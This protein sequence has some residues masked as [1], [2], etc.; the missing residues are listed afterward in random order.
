MDAKDIYAALA[1]EFG[2]AVEPSPE[3]LAG[4]PFVC[5][6]PEKLR[7]AL[8]R[9]RQDPRLAMEQLSIVSGVDRGEWIEVVYHLFS[10]THNHA[11][12]IK[13]KLDPQNPEVD[14][15]VDLWGAAEWH[16]RETFDLVGIRFR[17]HP[18]LRRILLPEDWE[19]HPLRRDYIQPER[20]HDIPDL[21][22]EVRTDS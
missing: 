16:E 3:G 11:A 10:Y 12:T 13:A 18:G 17:G 7:E 6:A 20:Y 14:S 4:D 1:E 19:G 8:G 9:L 5:V 15:V 22:E 21:P 2:E